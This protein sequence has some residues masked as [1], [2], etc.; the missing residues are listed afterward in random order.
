M[1]ETGSEASSKPSAGASSSAPSDQPSGAPAPT[2]APSAHRPI[3]SFGGRGPSRG[4]G[5]GRGMGRSGSITGNVISYSYRRGSGRGNVNAAVPGSNSW[6]R[7]QPSST[8]SAGVSIP[9]NSWVRPKDDDRNH[10]RNVD[11]LIHSSA[12]ETSTASI[13]NIG[14]K[15]ATCSALLSARNE[16][17]SNETIDSN[18]GEGSDDKSTAK[19]AIFSEETEESLKDTSNPPQKKPILKGGP[20]PSGGSKVWRRKSDDDIV[21]AKL[22]PRPNQQPPQPRH[23]PAKGKGKARR[24]ANRRGDKEPA[25]KRIRLG[26]G[27]HGTTSQKGDDTNG[28]DTTYKSEGKAERDG[29]VA[30]LTAFAYRETGTAGQARRPVSGRRRGRG[31][32]NNSSGNMGLVRVK[33]ELQ[34]STKI[35][36]TFARGVNCDDEYCRKRHD[37]PPECARPLCSFFQRHGQCRKGDDCP[38]AHVKV[39]PRAAVCSSFRLLGY[40]EDPKCVF[41]HVLK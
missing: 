10:Q 21:S 38:F 7:G 32:A 39:D 36:P 15:D 6:T 22:K 41:K 20:K 29:N 24:N 28:N 30:T 8:K 27:S 3:L 5:R 9:S 18:I 19:T 26:G 16:T 14:E 31:N 23:L 25:A 12:V 1:P 33:S 11:A 35:C 4:R 17:E 40:C 37:V 13:E 2:A 34:S